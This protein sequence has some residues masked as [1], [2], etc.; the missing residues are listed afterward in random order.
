MTAAAT[1][2]AVRGITTAFANAEA[3]ARP[4]ASRTRLR[5]QLDGFVNLHVRSFAAHI[6]RR[7]CGTVLAYLV[8]EPVDLI[9]D[10]RVQFNGLVREVDLRQFQGHIDVKV[11]FC[12]TEKRVLSPA[13]WFHP[14]MIE[15]VAQTEG[16]CCAD[17]PSFLERNAICFEG[18]IQLGD[19]QPY[20]LFG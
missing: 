12:E 11:G 2:G 4:G 8:K 7:D 3:L 6:T 16:E 20:K 9:P 5:K 14:L 18:A 17:L 13:R 15:K 10:H 1:A 19:D